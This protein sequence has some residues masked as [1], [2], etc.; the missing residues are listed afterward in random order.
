MQGAGLG[1][2][3]ARVSWVEVV[4]LDGGRVGQ[5]LIWCYGRRRVEV[6]VFFVLFVF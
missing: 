6:E 3:A 4:G 2:H 5:V 1:Q